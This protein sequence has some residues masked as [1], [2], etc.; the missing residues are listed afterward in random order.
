MLAFGRF[1][2]GAGPARGGTGGRGAAAA[3]YDAPL[4]GRRRA[5]ERG[6]MRYIA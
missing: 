1:G 5:E 6:I 3:R 4:A 2:R